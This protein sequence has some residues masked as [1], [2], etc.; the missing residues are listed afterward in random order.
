M[1]KGL[2]SHD[3][4]TEVLR[5]ERQHAHEKFKGHNWGNPP[6]RSACSH[7]LGVS[8]EL[9]LRPPAHHDCLSTRPQMRLGAADAPL[10]YIELRAI[11]G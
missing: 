8:S 6:S 1:V 5:H 4:P 3:V 7:S 2:P 10:G 9:W 11:E